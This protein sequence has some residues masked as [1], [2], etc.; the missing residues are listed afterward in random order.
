[1]VSVLLSVDRSTRPAVMESATASWRTPIGVRVAKVVAGGA[2][3][4]PVG[5]RNSWLYGSVIKRHGVGSAFLKSS[6]AASAWSELPN[7]LGNVGGRISE[8]ERLRV[9]FAELNCSLIAAFSLSSC[10]ISQRL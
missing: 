2:V 5:S 9:G 10:T 8:V 4:L 1:V 7:G 3:K 6:L